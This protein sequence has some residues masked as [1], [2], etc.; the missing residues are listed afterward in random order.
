LRNPE[1][2]DEIRTAVAKWQAGQDRAERQT[3]TETTRTMRIEYT[4]VGEKD[5]Q[6]IRVATVILSNPPVNALSERLLDE[7]ETTLTHISRREEI[8]AIVLAGN[9][10]KTFI[11]GADLRQ[12]LEDVHDENAA[13]S[14]PSKAHAV[15]NLIE[16][17]QKPVIAAVEGVALGGG[18][19]MALACHLR[20]ANNRT[21]FGQPEI[22]L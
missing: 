1:C 15:A 18:C 6:E 3:I 8:G 10:A 17:M 20:V 21:L 11:A 14:L 12:L 2:L 7:L 9:G 16:N 5:G 13:R 4:P 22:N 19:E